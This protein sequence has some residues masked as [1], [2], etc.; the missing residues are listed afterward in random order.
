MASQS[1]N[2]IVKEVRR[3]GCSATD[4]VLDPSCSHFRDPSIDGL[5]GYHSS[6]RCAVVYGDPVCAKQ[7]IPALTQAFH[8]FCQ[9][10]RL[11]VV[12]I[13]ISDEF[14]Q[15]LVENHCKSMIQFGH[16]MAID[17]Y[18][19]PRDKHGEGARLVRRK[20]HHAESEGVK[21]FEYREDNPQIEEEM[22]EI[23][24]RWAEER[25][26]PQVHIANIFLFENRE[27]K[28]WFYAKQGEKMVGIALINQLQ[29]KQGWLL[30]HLMMTL[31]AP[32]GVPESLVITILDQLKL[33]GCRYVSFGVVPSMELGKMVGMGRLSSWMLRRLFKML[34]SVLPFGGLEKFW[35]KF[36]PQSQPTYLVCSRS[37][38]GLR[39]LLALKV[40]LKVNNR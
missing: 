37:R 22:E 35:S 15:W 28:R 38:P 12:Y 1:N 26:G 40:A 14:A 25:K 2:H 24:K 10:K 16:E 34:R 11:Q 17:P 19:N 39:E 21:V 4:A 23:A 30:N 13:I 32:A 8:R 29:A 18:D 27:G 6:P 33:E 36:S 20:L 5:I 3:W 9:E 7:D 31:E